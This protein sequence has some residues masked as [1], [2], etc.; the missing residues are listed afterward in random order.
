MKSEMHV[1]KD[2]LICR[3]CKTASITE[4]VIMIQHAVMQVAPRL[5]QL[6]NHLARLVIT[7]QKLA[8][9]KVSFVVDT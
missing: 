6:D 3:A 1:P 7:T 2:A 9:H 8:M 4:K 5:W